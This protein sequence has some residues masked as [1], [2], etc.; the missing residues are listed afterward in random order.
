MDQYR[1]STG[2]L[3]ARFTIATADRRNGP[4]LPEVTRLGVD[5]GEA[6]VKW[7][8]PRLSRD[9]QAAWYIE[10]GSVIWSNL[11]PVSGRYRI[12]FELRRSEQSESGRDLDDAYEVLI[13]GQAVPL[14]WTQFNTFNTGNAWFG[15]ALTPPLDLA[16]QGR[17]I[18]IRTT[19]PW[20]A[21]RGGFFLVPAQ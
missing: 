2:K 21:I 15:Y 1:E 19:K 13:D 10:P 12:R 11:R 9:A 14:E 6:S 8:C 4:V 18:E 3:K 7:D 16:T 17:S 5:R 20:C